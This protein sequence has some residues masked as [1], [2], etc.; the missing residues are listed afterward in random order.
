VIKRPP[1]PP[2]S[3]FEPFLPHKEPVTE[4]RELIAKYGNYIYYQES[5]DHK[6]VINEPELIHDIFFEHDANF[7]KPY[8]DAKRALGEALVVSSGDYHKEHRAVMK[9]SFDHKAVVG[10]TETML[11]LAV[12]SR[13]RLQDG[14]EFDIYAEMNRLTAAII[15][16]CMFS[17]QIEDRVEDIRK[18]VTRAYE[19]ELPTTMPFSN[20]LLKLP[21]PQN[22]KFVT[23]MNRVH[24]L[25][26]DTIHERKAEGEPGCQHGDLL[27]ALIKAQADGSMHAT[28]AQLHAEI[29]GIFLGG[30]E[31]TANCLAFTWHLLSQNPEA[32]K[33][34]HQELDTVLEGRLPKSED[35]PHLRYTRR[36]LSESMRIFPPAWSIGRR[37]IN[38]FQ[39]GDYVIPAG[40]HV[41]VVPCVTHIDERFWPDPWRFDPDRFLPE[42]IKARPKFAYFPFGAGK[43]VCLGEAFAWQ[44]AILCLAV[45]GQKWRL[46]RPSGAPLPTEAHITLRPKG[47]VPVKP[48][49]R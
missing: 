40:S 7:T 18:T 22:I 38:D 15:S 14:V 9:G 28:D 13:D 44:E 25:L 42:N 47:E 27:S 30:H 32:E 31:T 45:L 6:Y 19:A 5:G 10:Y 11:D 46:T 17:L 12:K 35:V 34:F 1:G 43:H 36:M 16:D 3:I 4:Y 37:A 20:I 21:L 2:H 23:A 29:Q 41:R 8:G 26:A 24:K 49:A 48:V 33:A 39:L